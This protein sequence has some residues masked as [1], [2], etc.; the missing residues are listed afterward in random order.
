MPSWQRRIVHMVVQNTEGVNS[1]SV[2]EG[3]NRHLVISIDDN[4]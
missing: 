1:E 4:A 3:E 2:G